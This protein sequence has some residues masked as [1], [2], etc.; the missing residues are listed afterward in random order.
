MWSAGRQA[1]GRA[2]TGGR[3]PVGA[4]RKGKGRARLDPAH[5]R[6]RLFTWLYNFRGLVSRWEYD[7]V[8]F[9]GFVQL[10]C[11]I[12]RWSDSWPISAHCK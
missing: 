7:V 11:I 1:D 9:L 8:N 5:I 2:A 4:A 12:L 10:G 3:T 6:E